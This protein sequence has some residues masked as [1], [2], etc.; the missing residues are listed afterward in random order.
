M[1]RVVKEVHARG[2]EPLKKGDPIFPMDPE[3][4][5]NKLDKA[6]A[7]YNIDHA[8]IYAPANGYCVN[9]QLRPGAFIRLKTP[10]VDFVTTDDYWIGAAANQK[11]VQWIESG[12]ECEIAL[13]LYP[14]K[15]F[16]CEVEHVV[17]ATAEAQ[18]SASGVLPKLGE[19][20]PS[21]HFALRLQRTGDW[22]DQP[23]R[24]GAKGLAAIYTDEAADIFVLLRK[25]EIRSESWLNYFYNPF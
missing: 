7:E 14:G 1:G 3:N 17:F 5:Q 20:K 18:L 15:V 23:L 16:P 8:T 22:P 6:K 24:Y 25:L 9:L 12:N 19:L 4:W 21:E 10:I 13:D 2:T 11:A